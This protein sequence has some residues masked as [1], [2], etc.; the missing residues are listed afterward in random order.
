MDRTGFDQGISG[1]GI[2]LGLF[3]FI[4]QKPKELGIGF[5]PN[6]T[7]IGHFPQML[8]QFFLSQPYLTTVVKDIAYLQR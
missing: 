4:L 3:R 2:A 6:L 1:K 5:S 7:L 8:Q